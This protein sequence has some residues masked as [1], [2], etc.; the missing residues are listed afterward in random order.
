MFYLKK[1]FKWSW[2][3]IIITLYMYSKNASIV[4][5]YQVLWDLFLHF[6]Y[7]LGDTTSLNCHREILPMLWILKKSCA[8]GWAW[9]DPTQLTYT[10]NRNKMNKV[11]GTCIWTFKWAQVA[12]KKNAYLL[13]LIVAMRSSTNLFVVSNKMESMQMCQSVSLGCTQMMYGIHA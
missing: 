1:E 10:L 2:K 7:R 6:L 8:Q 13:R 9:H 11:W 5:E 4:N 3:I 12:W